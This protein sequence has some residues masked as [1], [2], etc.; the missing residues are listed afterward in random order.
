MHFGHSFSDVPKTA[1]Q[2]L[3]LASLLSAFQDATGPD[4][5]NQYNT[6]E[7]KRSGGEKRGKETKSSTVGTIGFYSEGLA[8]SC[9]E[10]FLL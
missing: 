8:L 6:M 4:H 1:L 10:S 5:K 9:K 3:Q 7:E 2:N